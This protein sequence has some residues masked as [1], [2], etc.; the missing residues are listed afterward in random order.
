[1]GAYDTTTSV[2]AGVSEIQATQHNQLVTALLHTMS[3]VPY[4]AYGTPASMTGNVTLTD[5]S[6][7]VLSYSPTAARDLTL[8]AVATTNHAFYVINRSG[9]YA[10]TVKNSGGT[11]IATIIA[12]G[13][14]VFVSDGVNGWYQIGGFSL[15]T[16]TL[17][18][19]DIA[20]ASTTNIATA[21]GATVT[22]T[23]STTITAFGTAN[24]G[25][26]RILKFSGAPLLTYDATSLILPTA[27]N[28][29]TAVGDV[30][31]FESL[32][33]G[34]WKCVGY[35]LASGR[36]ITPPL[37]SSVQVVNT[38]TGAVA[39]GITSIPNDDT[40]PQNTEGDE[41][42]QLAISPKNASNFLIIDVVVV[43][44]NSA[45][46]FIAA[47]LFKD[48]IADALA[49]AWQN[50]AVINYVVTVNFRHYMVAGTTSSI[51]FKVRAGGVAAGTTTFNGIS[52]ARKFGGVMSSSITI[53]EIKV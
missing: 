40:I 16:L 32:G 12:N 7:P 30:F 27:A 23:G 39:T 29:Q 15:D 13:I 3:A 35:I 2:V 19:A 5:A 53:T 28:V 34:N 46:N 14:S 45:V 26:L 6:F 51:T 49:V 38:Q 52:G 18:G 50:I 24:A 1:M 8:P 21:T 25:V 47:A 31:I 22:I 43:L 36:A 44:A 4:A 17:Q 48:S 10:I 9:T 33:S 41:Y 42:M 37:G 11:T 20:S